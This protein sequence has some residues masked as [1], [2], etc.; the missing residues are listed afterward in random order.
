[1]SWKWFWVVFL[2]WYAR[3]R[4]FKLISVF[5]RFVSVHKYFSDL[6]TDPLSKGEILGKNPVN[7]SNPH[8]Q[9]VLVLWRW[10]IFW[11]P[12]IRVLAWFGVHKWGCCFVFFFVFDYCRNKSPWT[13]FENTQV[14]SWPYFEKH[15][16]RDQPFDRKWGI[17]LLPGGCRLYIHESLVIRCVLFCDF[18][19]QR[20]SSLQV[21]KT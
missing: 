15:C 18:V 20:F 4:I 6:H 3:L 12:F 21:I 13:C 17:W 19:N 14:V 8:R 9:K 16:P 7:L 10:N 11:L 1:M 5:R 2:F